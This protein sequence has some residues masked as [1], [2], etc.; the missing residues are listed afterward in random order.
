[1]ITAIKKIFWRPLFMSYVRYKRWYTVKFVIPPY[2][3]KRE[4]LL[5]YKTKYGCKTF[6]ET[7]T[8][9]GDTV[10][11][12]KTH[13]DKVFSIELASELAKKAQERFKND[14]N[15]FIIEGDSGKKLSEIIPQL[16]PPVLYWLDGHFS[17]ACMID[18]EFIQTATADLD[19]PIMS[20]LNAVLS[21]G[22]LKNNVIL[23]DDARLFNG[24]DGYPRYESLVSHLKTLGISPNQVSVERDIIRI[25]PA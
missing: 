12:M 4:I 19:T 3:E 13:F 11:R 5:S 2:G 17:G 6:V 18:G 1:M 24:S 16:L 7:G 20:E 22:G 14:A 15:V 21:N 25:V 9:L 23:I 10:E 8:F